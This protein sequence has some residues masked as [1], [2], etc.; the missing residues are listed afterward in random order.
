M[1]TGDDQNIDEMAEQSSHAK[2]NDV[3]IINDTSGAGILARDNGVLEGFSYYN[4]G[5]RLDPATMTIGFFAP[6]IRMF[7][8]DFQVVSGDQEFNPINDEYAEILNMIGGKD[9]GEV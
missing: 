1:M 4:L 7:T 5:F 3:G 9:N 8:N 6:K 2:T